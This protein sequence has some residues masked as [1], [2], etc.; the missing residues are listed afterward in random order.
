MAL[1]VLSQGSSS[2]GADSF[3]FTVDYD[4]VAQTIGLT[5]TGS[6]HAELTVVQ[7]SNGQ[8]LG[9]LWADQFGTTT[10]AISMDGA[11]GLAGQSN[12][13]VTYTGNRVVVMGP[14][15]TGVDSSDNPLST[16]KVS[17]QVVGQFNVPKGQTP[18]LSITLDWNPLP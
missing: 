5:C 10:G 7:T 6:G 3:S 15:A 4:T 18:G 11:N 8:S 2:A 16:K 17:S 13:P 1:E 12:G 14:G 9:S